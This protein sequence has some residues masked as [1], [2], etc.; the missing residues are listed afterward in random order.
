MDYGEDIFIFL[1]NF[2]KTQVLDQNPGLKD[3]KRSWWD[4]EPQ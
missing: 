3:L 4:E 2:M 1:A